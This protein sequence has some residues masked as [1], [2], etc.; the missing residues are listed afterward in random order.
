MAN[1]QFTFPTA[2]L[3]SPAFTGV[4]TAPT[5]TAG[6]N[7]TQLATTAFVSTA[8]SGAGNDWKLTGNAG[9]SAA[10][11]FVGTTDA[12]NLIFRRNNV[13]AG[14]ITDSTITFG[15]GA[16]AASI[17]GGQNVLLGPNSGNKI[18][19]QFGNVSIGNSALFNAASN[20]NTAV[21]DGAGAGITGGANNVFVGNTA[22]TNTGS[23][24]KCL[25]IGYAAQLPAGNNRLNL[26]NVLWGI[27]CDGILENP[28]GSLSIGAV[29]P[30]ASAIFDLTSTSQGFGLPQLTN[31]AI[32]AIASPKA[33]L[34]LYNTTINHPCFYNGTA[35]QRLSHSPM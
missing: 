6:T 33:G 19:T 31:A 24:T 15:V 17:S 1:N 13:I 14:R 30:N 26:G 21:G 28:A 12:T 11:N 18:T 23:A 27:N 10:T 7:T 3:N 2:P 34:M 5:A 22:G 20:A 32:L 35:W 29:S 8:V 16:G 9:T 4:P 25:A